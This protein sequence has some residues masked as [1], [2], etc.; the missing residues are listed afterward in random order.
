ME[1][2]FPY[3][4]KLQREY[5]KKRGRP[6]RNA[7]KKPGTKPTRP[8]GT[9]HRERS[10]SVMGELAAPKYRG[11]SLKKPPLRKGL[12]TYL[13]RKYESKARNPKPKPPGPRYKP[14][15]WYGRVTR[16]ERTVPEPGSFKHKQR[17]GRTK[18]RYF[19]EMK[20]KKPKTWAERNR[21]SGTV[22]GTLRTAFPLISKTY[23][24]I[25]DYLKTKRLDL[26]TK[27]G[28]RDKE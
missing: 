6:I 14:A 26:D 22:M 4:V 11:T 12:D 9:T 17:L 5:D 3:N 15:P 25:K 19:R 21:A 10:L 27:L 1:A 20:Y 28:H 18:T 23:D 16:T 2:K 8:A 7:S 13:T 24:N